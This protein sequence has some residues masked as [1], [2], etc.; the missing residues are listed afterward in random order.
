MNSQKKN[1]KKKIVIKKKKKKK[2]GN[3]GVPNDS[4]Q[5][6][7]MSHLKKKK[8]KFNYLRICGLLYSCLS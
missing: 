4:K 6:R 5:N 8:Y 2:K 7:E 1:Y 3:N